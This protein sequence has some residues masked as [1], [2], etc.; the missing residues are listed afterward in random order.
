MKP[1]VRMIHISYS[2]S[3]LFAAIT[4]WK[5]QR[6]IK[7]F[8]DL[9]C[10]WRQKYPSWRTEPHGS[11]RGFN[12]NPWNSVLK[13]ENTRHSFQGCS[14]TQQHLILLLSLPSAWLSS[15][16][17][18]TEEWNLRC[19]QSNSIQTIGQMQ[20]NSLRTY[21]SRKGLFYVFF[22]PHT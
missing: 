5:S 1:P 3:F 18:K 19:S 21:I 7:C 6:M 8:F 16:C 11:D 10:M 4:V 2:F 20:N 12:Y 9:P 13:A 22:R 17:C 15:R 14:D